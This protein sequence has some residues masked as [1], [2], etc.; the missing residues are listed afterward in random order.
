M[1]RQPEP[2]KTIKLEREQR[3]CTLLLL[4]G[5]LVV[6]G[7]ARRVVEYCLTANLPWVEPQSNALISVDVG[8]L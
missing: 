4:S 5:S 8:E 1:R 3:A 2:G 7:P 6:V